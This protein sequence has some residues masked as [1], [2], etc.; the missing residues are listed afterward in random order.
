MGWRRRG[1]SHLGPEVQSLCWKKMTE[2]FSTWTA[3]AIRVRTGCRQE[4]GWGWKSLVKP[5]TQAG[6][7][8]EGTT[9]WDGAEQGDW[10]FKV[11][12]EDV[13]QGKA[14]GFTLNRRRDKG[15][16]LDRTRDGCQYTRMCKSKSR[17]NVDVQPEVF[18][19]KQKRIRAEQETWERKYFCA[20]IAWS[21]SFF[22]GQVRKQ[23]R[24]MY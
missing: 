15:R 21:C 6:L 18:T 4:G 17:E 1:P 12:K 9:S 20:R 2:G 19:E 24:K 7:Y 3:A 16:L 8:T 22:N 10:D 5:V 14:K 13:K 23:N 11:P